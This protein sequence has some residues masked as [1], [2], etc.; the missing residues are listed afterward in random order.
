MIQNIRW[1]KC[2]ACAKVKIYKG[3]CQFYCISSF[4]Y[5]H[6]KVNQL[7]NQQITNTSKQ[8]CGYLLFDFDWRY[9]GNYDSALCKQE[10]NDVW[11]K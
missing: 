1:Y 11:N 3:N 4:K 6:Y 9:A 2:P 7:K 5:L 8:S 10:D